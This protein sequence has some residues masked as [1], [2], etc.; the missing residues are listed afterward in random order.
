VAISDDVFSDRW[1]ERVPEAP[2]RIGEEANFVGLLSE[3]ESMA[4]RSVPMVRSGRLG[5]YFVTDIPMHDGAVEW[6]EPMVHLLDSYS[7][8]GFSGA[9]CFA[10]HPVIRPGTAPSE[11]VPGVEGA[12]AYA[13]SAS[14][15]SRVAL[16]GVVIGHFRSERGENEGVAIVAPVEA[17]REVLDSEVLMKWRKRMDSEA[18]KSEV[19]RSRRNA[20]T[21][22][23]GSTEQTEFDRFEGLT[24]TLVNAPKPEK[25]G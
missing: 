4:D 5:A 14:I 13:I 2:L 11:P 3:A 1:H 20:A 24:R 21:A 10:D 18:A 22:D 17:V 15:T 6:T 16:V 25:K 8:G 19:E 9:P 23:S 7:R 12:A